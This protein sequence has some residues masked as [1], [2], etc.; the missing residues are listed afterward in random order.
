M[1]IEP[2][3]LERYFAKY[4][5]S[6]KY[7]LSSS[8]CESFLMSDLL[9][10]ADSDN[11]NLWEN[12]KLGYTESPGHP[13]LRKEISKIYKDISDDSIV[14]CVPEEGIFLFMN[15]LL[16]KG[17]HIIC[18]FPG[19][20]SLYEVA[21]SIGCE[22][23]NW[24]PDEKDGWKFHLEHLKLMIQPN[25]KL[26]VINFP[27]N[28]TGYAPAENE[29]NEIINI[30]RKN[31]LFLLSDEMYR[32]LE[33]KENS[34]LPAACDLYDRAFSLCGLSK[35]YGLPG[36]RIGWIASHYAETMR[37]IAELKDYTTICS[38]AP[39]EILAI[40]GLQ[41][42]EEINNQ[43]TKLI[44]KNINLLDIFFQ[45][46]PNFFSY[47]KPVGGSVCFPKMLNAV[48]TKDFCEKLIQDTG[49]MLLPSKVFLYDDSHVRVGF[50]R[51]NFSEV[52][53]KFEKYLKEIIILND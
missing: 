38:S 7:L 28:P 23:S 37:R 34:I 26:I 36:L 18:T 33:V 2:F 6:A 5:F 50:G 4:E 44:K 43:L 40:I 52:L 8:D 12:L 45:K 15:A 53:E 3:A 19:Y 16:Q 14:V 1:K 41:N 25:T 13:L 11:K 46:Y 39:S 48:S 51:K 27:H 10:L 21:R 9:N 32:F 35:S 47:N 20:Q 42:R 29:F 30:A 22:I 24:E 49:I 31:N 17:D